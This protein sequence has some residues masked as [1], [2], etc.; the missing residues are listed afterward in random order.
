MQIELGMM[1]AVSLMGIAVQFQILKILMRKMKEIE[2]EQ[3]PDD[4]E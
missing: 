2:E 1:G 3:K 4:G